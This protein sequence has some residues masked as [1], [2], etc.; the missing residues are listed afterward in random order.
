MFNHGAGK[1]CQGIQ[2]FIRQR[3]L[4][5]QGIDNSGIGFGFMFG[6]HRMDGD[7]VDAMVFDTGG[8]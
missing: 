5:T 1:S 3:L 6:K 8:K 4:F 2:L 7:A